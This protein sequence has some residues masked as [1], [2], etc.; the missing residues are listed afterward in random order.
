MTDQDKIRFKN[1]IGALCAA[2]PSAPDVPKERLAVY[3]AVLKGQPIEAV[4]AATEAWLQRDTAWFP[5]AGQL[6][7]LCKGQTENAAT[8][9]WL[10]VVKEVR[11]VGYM[12]TPTLPE[13][14][15]QAVRATW[16]SWRATCELLPDADSPMFVA[17]AKRFES[18]YNALAERRDD[19][20]YLGPAEAKRVLASVLND[21]DAHRRGLAVAS[22]SQR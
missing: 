17:I 7:A 6:L 16:G 19:A 9:A 22:G 13:T 20:N 11:R 14:T 4:E 2:L 15:M 21:V 12:R 10:D 3:F 5:S 18:A 1:A 8:L